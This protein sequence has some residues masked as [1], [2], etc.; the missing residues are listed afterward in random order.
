MMAAASNFRFSNKIKGEVRGKIVGRE[1]ELE[2]IL[3]A[4][5][6]GRHVLLEGPPGTSKTTILN[7]ICESI[8][9]PFYLLE[10]NADLTPAKLLGSFDPSSV[11]AHGFKPEM[12]IKG[13]LTTAFEE[14]GI[15]F[16][17]EF[18]RMA[19]DASNVLIRA[20]EEEE[21]IIPRFGRINIHPAFRL[22]C[23][24]NPYDDTGVTKISRA[25]YDR[26]IRVKMNY[27]SI[28]EERNIVKMHVEKDVDPWLIEVGIRLG[29]ATRGHPELKQGASVRGAID[30]VE[31]A[32]ILA[33]RRGGY[34]L[35]VLVDATFAAMSGKV[36]VDEAS[37][38]D[39]EEILEEV[40]GSVLRS[41]DLDIPKWS[42]KGKKGR[43]R[44]GGTL[45]KK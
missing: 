11:I 40:L 22:V 31:L 24:Q 5:D 45:G 23:G 36:W 35:D 8:G 13:P 44:D 21:L 9:L 6:S 7:L 28:E 32:P 19:P 20:I 27:Q 29:W 30:F 41:I 18:N 26:L 43:G 34:G 3:A 1:R 38:R 25:L 2:I 37:D 12:F 10:G 16:I 42:P 15:L 33:E 4:L 14:G 39:S 17:D